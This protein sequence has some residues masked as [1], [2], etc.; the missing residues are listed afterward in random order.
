MRKRTGI[1]IVQNV[2]TKATSLRTKLSVFSDGTRRYGVPATFCFKNSTDLNYISKIVI[3]SRC[4]VAD[5]SDG[6]DVTL[7]GACRRA[8]RTLCLVQYR[9]SWQTAELTSL[10]S[11]G[12]SLTSQ[13][14]ELEAK[15]GRFTMNNARKTLR[16]FGRCPS[17][18]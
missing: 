7:G 13:R 10:R 2:K 11:V 5:K 1:T 3:V 8:Q 18:F 9:T 16:G 6:Q 4:S 12:L 15:S 14:T 17:I